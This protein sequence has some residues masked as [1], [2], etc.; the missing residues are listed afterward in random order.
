M[1]ITSLTNG[2]SYAFSIKAINIK[3]KSQEKNIVSKPATVPSKVEN[4]SVTPGKSK[5]TLSWSSPSNDGGASITSYRISSPGLSTITTESRSSEILNLTNGQQYVFTVEAKNEV[6]WGSKSDEKSGTPS[7][8]PGTPRSL[9]VDESD[10]KITLS[11]LP[12]LDDG[13]ASISEYEISISPA[14][15]VIG[16]L[17]VVQSG[18]QFV[19]N[20]L[21]NG[22]NY[23]FS[24]TAKNING[25]GQTSDSVSGTPTGLPTAPIG[26][27]LSSG[28]QTISS[29][30]SPP[31]IMEV[32]Q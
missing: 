23:T 29:S 5:V 10:K 6:G 2:V 20:Q 27:N 7:S 13:G 30:W 22:T 17:K 31:S 12:P 1:S 26:L 15:P 28:N 3:G 14:I 32:P 25:L 16:N 4:L 19:F 8:E 24:V 18:N 9:S 11:W 21:T